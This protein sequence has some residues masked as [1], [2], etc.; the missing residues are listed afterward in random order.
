MPYTIT[1]LCYCPC[2]SWQQQVF[3]RLPRGLS[4]SACKHL[5]AARLA[6]AAGTLVE[7]EIESRQE[8]TERMLAGSKGHH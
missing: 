5:L 2:A 7:T 8:F 6:E 4:T 3:L 1:D